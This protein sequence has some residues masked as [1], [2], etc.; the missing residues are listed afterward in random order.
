MR[1]LPV[2]LVLAIAAGT[3]HAQQGG[4]RFGR[5]GQAQANQKADP[6]QK[7]KAEEAFNSGVKR[8]PDPK[9]KFDPWKGAR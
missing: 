9:D 5:K 6:Q 2:M 4:D 1:I 7:K 3:A 8:I